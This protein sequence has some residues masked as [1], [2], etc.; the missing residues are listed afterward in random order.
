MGGGGGLV[1]FSDPSLKFKWHPPLLVTPVTTVQLLEAQNHYNLGTLEMVRSVYEACVSTTYIID[2]AMASLVHSC[3]ALQLLR[4]NREH[5]R[6][7]PK[8]HLVLIRVS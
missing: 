6:K 1:N 5:L 3:G 2:L 7:S 8:L 4:T